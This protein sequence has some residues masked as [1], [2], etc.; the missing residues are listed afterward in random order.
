[1]TSASAAPSVEELTEE[2]EWEIETA[3]SLR[4][5]GDHDAA[6]AW[7]RKAADKFL[8]AGLDDR[9]VQV[10]RLAASLDEA[11][12]AAPV[13]SMAPPKPP[14]VSAAPP[15]PPVV[16]VAPPPVVIAPPP[17]PPVV[18]I[19]PPPA[20]SVAPPVESIPAAAVITVPPPSGEPSIQVP[21]TFKTD[22]MPPMPMVEMPSIQ[23]THRPAPMPLASVTP[24]QQHPAGEMKSSRIPRAISQPPISRR[25]LVPPRAAS[26]YRPERSDEGEHLAARLTALPLF[27]DLTSETVRLLARQVSEVRFT[28][29]QVMVRATSREEHLVDTPLLVI[30]EGM[31]LHHAPDDE[32][33]GTMLGPGDFVGEIGA[34]VGGGGEGM[35][36]ARSEVKV[37]ALSASLV[38]ALMAEQASVRNVLDET[39]WERA[40]GS[41]GRTAQLFRHV[42]T[43]TRAAF[44]AKFEPVQLAPGELLLGEGAP[45][46]HVWLVACGEVELYGGGLN[47][48]EVFRARAGDALGVWAALSSEPSGLSARALRPTLAARATASTFRALAKLHPAMELAKLDVGVDGRGVV[49]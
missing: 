43:A 12:P 5:K 36:T 45:P 15:P 10:A 47:P 11:K 42:D 26:S 19:A 48:M 35:A 27:A 16:S 49:S 6:R 1:M 20:V 40:F 28:A 23:P 24:T 38:R 29:G 34:C 7:Y 46:S 37:I 32:A 25:S 3:E 41:L 2:A 4:A 39:L 17:P 8:D 13:A 44:Y 31:V 33:G 30:V 22:P 14:V 18:S 21:S 9:A